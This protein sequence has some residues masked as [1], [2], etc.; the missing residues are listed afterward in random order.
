MIRYYIPNIY[1][2]DYITMANLYVLAM[3]VLINVIENL[4]LTDII[5][6]I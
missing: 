6:R 3:C 5:S 1:I 2:Y 4:Y